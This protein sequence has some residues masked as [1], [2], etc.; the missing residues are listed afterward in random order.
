MIQKL[1][2]LIISLFLITTTLSAQNINIQDDNIVAK[3]GDKI[4]TKREFTERFDLNP[5]FQKHSLRLLESNKLEFLFTLIGEKLLALEAEKNGLDTTLGVSSAIE[6]IEKVYARDALFQNEIRSKIILTEEEI[7]FGK[8]KNANVLS[9]KYAFSESSEIIDNV[10]KSL[11]KGISFDSLDQVMTSN[12]ELNINPIEVRFG[13]LLESIE[14]SVYKLE[15]NEYTKPLFAPDG[16]YIFYLLN[17]KEQQFETVEDIENADKTV[18]KILEGR[19]GET[20]Q[21]VFYKEFFK[22]KKVDVDPVLYKYLLDKLIKIFKSKEEAGYVSQDRLWHLDAFD[23]SNIEFEAD[24][25]KLNQNFILFENS[26][27][28]FHNFLREFLLQGFSLTSISKENISEN[29]STQIRIIIERE[30]LAREAIKRG[31]QNTEDVVH[32]KNIWKDHYLSQST[33]DTFSKDVSIS[34]S[35][36]KDFYNKSFK[37]EIYPQQ[38]NLSELLVDSLETLNNFLQEINGDKVAFKEKV[39]TFSKSK[40]MNENGESGYIPIIKLKEYE[41]IIS[42]INIG[43][44]SQPLKVNEGYSSILLIDKKEAIVKEK[45]KSFEEAKNEIRR[46]LTNEEIFHDLVEKTVQ[47]AE[48]TEI[49]INT[50]VLKD[51]EIST[52]N[53]FAVRVMGF[54]GKITAVPISKPFADWARIWLNNKQLIP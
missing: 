51:V 44:I 42:K 45:S 53:S 27:T 2:K 25:E 4:I 18:R 24:S 47:L 23:V 30:L 14:D 31:L 34:D 12:L 1:D 50:E 16:W 5:Q 35:L 21:S 40:M 29:L 22:D 52:I 39:K 49:T 20:I 28:T 11:Q 32:Y 26:P 37:K 8:V 9:V 15:I 48:N 54:G 33:I 6:S 36:M 13:D 38:I 3:I 19:K 46:Q 17:K 7:F 43:E 10:Y 41:E